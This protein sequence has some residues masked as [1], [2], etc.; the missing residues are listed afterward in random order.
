MELCKD[1]ELEQGWS[2]RNLWRGIWPI[3]MLGNLLGATVTFIYFAFI[4]ARLVSDAPAVDAGDRIAFF[5][6]GMVIIMA[7]CSLIGLSLVLPARRRAREL[8]QAG[9]SESLNSAAGLL[10]DM[11]LKM[12]GVSLIGW[13]SA[14]IFFGFGPPTVNWFYRAD[15]HEATRQFCGIVFVG[16]PFTVSYIF[17]VLEY[18]LRRS[19]R[20]HFPVDSLL[21]IP[22]SRRTPILPKMV[23][24]SLLISICPLIIISYVTLSQ[25]HA[26]NAGHQTVEHFLSGM[27]LVIGFLLVLGIWMAIEL[28]TLISLSVSKPLKDAGKTMERIRGGDLDA[29]VPVIS[30]DE[31]GT[32]GEGLN[33]MIEGLRERDY[34][35]ET[36]GRYL[37]EQIVAEILE[38]PGGVKLGGELRDIT[39]LVSDLRGFTSMTESLAP[40]KVLE[41]IN[42]YLE[43][44]TDV[45][46]RHQ[47]TI[48]E[49]A[50]DGILVFFGAPVPIANATG[51]AVACALEMQ[52]ALKELNG[53]SA[54]LGFPELQMGI[55]VNCGELVVG[56]IGSEKRKKY[57]AMGTPINVAFRVEAQTSGGEVLVT[58]GIYDRLSD[59]LEVAA[60]RQASL[61][62]FEETLTL[63]QVVGMKWR[64]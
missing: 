56:N 44:M 3:T 20:K 23:L 53:E 29:S 37:S 27:P 35:R 24:G 36:F 31:I 42:R 5:V 34:I 17:L 32:M 39:I 10:M 14:G 40:E 18:W 19:V 22:S 55:G 12:A 21:T 28:S 30:N 2:P 48:D 26:I 33:R 61:K 9:D 16:A 1:K 13:L 38:S 6:V 57:G 58:P 51:R 52:T 43:R 59:D 54:A 60:A 7:V 47:G 8:F 25:I 63:Y 15:Y 4:E 11:P 49:F 41:I 45:I 62:G 50:G 64:G 46:I